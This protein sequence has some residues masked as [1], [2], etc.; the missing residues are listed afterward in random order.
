MFVPVAT[1]AAF[2]VPS[3]PG[4][5]SDVRLCWLPGDGVGPEVAEQAEAVL[6]AC[7][8]AGTWRLSLERG[9][10]GGAAIDVC[11]LPLQDATLEV[12]RGADAVFKG[13]VGGPKWD[14]LRGEQR[15]EAGL[16]R[17]RQELG[18]YANL[19]PTIVNPALAA[20]SPLR[21]ECLA[22]GVDILIVR[23]LNGGAYFGQPRG[24]VG[25]RAVDTMAYTVSEVDRL[26]RVGFEA[27]RLRRGL[28]TSV[29]KA[30]VLESSRL[31]RD[32]VTLVARDYPDVTLE[33]QLVDSC[34]MLLITR[35]AHFDVI[36]TENLFG[37]ILSDEAGVLAGS[38]GMLPSASL[39]VPG[40]PGLYEPVHG[41]APDIAGSGRANPIAAILTVAM[42]LRHSLGRPDE[43]AAVEGAVGDALAEGLRTADIAGVGGIAVSTQ[44]MGAAIRRHLAVR[45]A[46]RGG[47]DVSARAGESVPMSQ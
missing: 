39:G 2:T 13:P 5:R 27:A 41:A 26:A 3:T 37:D 23:E 22:G 31:W 34:A 40:Q 4:P 45:L 1:P 8:H 43:A 46:G 44:E 9:L 32:V 20:C 29:D 30:N 47:P 15:C 6:R 12:A 14:H 28:V 35:P 19:R 38:L 17:L 7:A 18:V 25:D 36:I 16:L 33:H 21:A 24:R 42:M 11:G 10:V